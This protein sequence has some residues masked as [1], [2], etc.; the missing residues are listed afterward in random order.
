LHVVLFDIDGTLTQSQSIDSEV[1]LRTLKVLFDFERVRSDWGTYTH[2]TDRGILHE[3][4]ADHRGAPPTAADIEGFR[5]HFVAEIEA[6]AAKE[7]FR[8]IPGAASMLRHVAELPDHFVGLATGGWRASARIKCLSAGVGFDAFPAASSDDAMSRTDIMTLSLERVHA[9]AGRSQA[10]LASLVYVGDGVWD[11]RACRKLGVPFIGIAAGKD[12]ARLAAEG[13]VAVLPD[14]SDPDAV[15]EA[16][17]AA[18][19]S[20]SAD[21]SR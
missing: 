5:A 18:Q 7:P 14:Y 15:R 3:V 21:T 13:A 4:F 20:L 19:A 1:Y 8:E 16:I 2:M 12:A 17:T 6:R 10:D 9:S 11:A